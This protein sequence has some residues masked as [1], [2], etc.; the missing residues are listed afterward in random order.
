[1]AVR[2]NEDGHKV[3]E[4]KGSVFFAS[5]AKFRTLFSPAT[6]PDDVVIEFRH[7][8]VGELHDLE[9]EELMAV[10]SSKHPL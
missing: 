7:A 5:A 6:D 10:V 9:K 4:L 3:Y 2:T 8:R 1:M